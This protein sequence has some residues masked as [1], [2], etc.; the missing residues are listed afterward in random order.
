MLS[1]QDRV[2]RIC[3]ECLLSSFFLFASNTALPSITR[4]FLSLTWWDQ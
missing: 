3:G 4:P 1:T 2:V